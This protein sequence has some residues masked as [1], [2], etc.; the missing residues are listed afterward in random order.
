MSQNNLKEYWIPSFDLLYDAC[1]YELSSDYIIQV[2]YWIDLAI[3]MTTALTAL[4]AAVT[5]LVLWGTP[6]GKML[7]GCLSIAAFGLVIFHGFISI[8]SRIRKEG[9]RRQGFFSLRV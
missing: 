8:P 9:E 5:G 4:A 1:F 3:S 6:S 2:W 7:W